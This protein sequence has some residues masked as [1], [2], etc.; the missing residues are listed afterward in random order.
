[1]KYLSKFFLDQIRQRLGNS[2]PTNRTERWYKILTY[3]ILFFWFLAMFPG[4]VGFDT[5]V[6]F[7]MMKEKSGTDWW[8]GWYWRILQLLTF[9]G[10]QVVLFSF[11]SYIFFWI[12]SFK[13]IDVYSRCL[14]EATRIKFLV[15]LIPIMPVFAMTVQHDVLFCI[16]ILVLVRKEIELQREEISR[17]NYFYSLF[18]VI[19][20]LLTT[21][22][23]I[24]L[25]PLLAFRILFIIGFK[26]SLTLTA[27]SLG[28]L[29][30]IPSS[31]LDHSWSR[32]AIYTPFL[33]DI[34]CAIQHP[35]SIVSSNA[36]DYLE[37]V[38]PKQL[39][40]KPYSCK[41]I[42]ANVWIKEVNYENLEIGQL[43]KVYAE[44]LPNHGE[45]F[46]M[47]HI[48][49][50]TTV[51]PPPFFRGPDNQV[52]LDYSN[53]IGEGTN[54]ALQKGVPLLH[55]SVDDPYVDIQLEITRPLAYAAQ[56]GIFFINQ[57]SRY[58]A[59]GGLW[60]WA[61]GIHHFLFR[62]RT[63]GSL[64]LKTYWYLVFLHLLFFIIG[65]SA[66]GRH[67]MPTIILGIITGTHILVNFFHSRVSISS[68]PAN[69]HQTNK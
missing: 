39:W 58:W 61:I 14:C 8:T 66:T 44:L 25:F 19:P 9:D 64:F 15:A 65:I 6:A 24:M 57:G 7:E 32:N 26:R 38:L 31:G 63:N 46:L 29:L 45:I 16:G 59:W 42:D 47:A 22:Q 56:V 18:Y 54:L 17:E 23:G 51:L 27:L 67:V 69:C 68:L 33:M 12:V 62:Y 50:S 49:R 35:H 2:L 37:N 36:W 53:P 11:V 40:L 60:F 3:L 21:K 28:F 10:R 1:M 48:Q 4:R 20:F 55:P 41:E 30:V 13:L 43:L 52:D 34:K 5:K